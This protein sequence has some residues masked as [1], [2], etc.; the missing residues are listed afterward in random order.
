MID[1][2]E[3]LQDYTIDYTTNCW[4]WNRCYGRDRYG[5][6]WIGDECHYVHRLVADLFIEPVIKHSTNRTI[7]HICSNKACVNP[8]H[9]V[10]LRNNQSHAMVHS[11]L[12][13]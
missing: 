13:I 5:S 2:L 9:L 3:R 10:V 1:I 7:H 6:L 4:I 11:I 8:E 12:K